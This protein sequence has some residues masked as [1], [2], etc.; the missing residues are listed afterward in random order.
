LWIQGHATSG[1]HEGTGLWPVAR[2]LASTW[3]IFNN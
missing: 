3:S 1:S 2:S